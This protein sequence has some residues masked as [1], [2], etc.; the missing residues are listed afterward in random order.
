MSFV[1]PA[2]GDVTPVT[3]WCSRKIWHATELRVLQNSFWC[4][5]KDEDED[6][7]RSAK[8]KRTWKV[9]TRHLKRVRDR[10]LFGNQIKGQKKSFIR[11]KKRRTRTFLVEEY[12]AIFSWSRTI[13]ARKDALVITRSRSNLA[14]MNR[15][16]TLNIKVCKESFAT[17]SQW[18]FCQLTILGSVHCHSVQRNFVFFLIFEFHVTLSC[19]WI[20]NVPYHPFAG[21]F[22]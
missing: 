3:Q 5:R 6:K 1:T 9:L 12:T 11:L 15:K 4:K 14:K 10:I 19:V 8:T 21:D 13:Q 2:A 16:C 18:L 17:R 20:R 7:R 22:G